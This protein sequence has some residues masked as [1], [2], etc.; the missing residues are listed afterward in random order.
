[1]EIIA[2]IMM[3]AHM[4]LTGTI[5]MVGIQAPICPGDNLEWDD[6][7][8]HIESVTHVCSINTNNGIKSFHTIVALSHGVSATP[9]SGVLGIYAGVYKDDQRSNEAPLSVEGED[10]NGGEKA[11]PASEPHLIIDDDTELDSNPTKALV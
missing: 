1:M 5:E 10:P 11:P 8:F 4:T 7:V 6:V 9:G 3:G 2:D